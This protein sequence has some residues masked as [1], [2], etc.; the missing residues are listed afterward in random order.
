MENSK[1]R[2]WGGGRLGGMAQWL[3]KCHSS[4]VLSEALSQ[5]STLITDGL[6]NSL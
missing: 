2:G 4:I 1:T 6:S 5:K 3:S